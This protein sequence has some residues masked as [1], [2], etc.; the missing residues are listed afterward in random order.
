MRKFLFLIILLSGLT[1]AARGQTMPEID[2]S[3]LPE[4]TTASSLRYWFDDGN[5]SVTSATI[6]AG[7]STADA[8]GLVD[9]IHVLHYQIIDSKGIVGI[10]FSKLFI[11]ISGAL[12]AKSLRYWF[13]DSDANS[14]TSVTGVNGN[15]TIETASLVDGIHIVHYQVVDNKGLAGIPFSK[16]FIKISGA[17]TAKSLRYWFDNNPN[18]VKTTTSIPSGA[19]PIDASGLVEGIHTI[20]YQIVDNNGT[21]GIPVSKM[22]MK[23]GAKTITATAIQYW[24][25]ENDANIKESA[26]DLDNLTTTVDASSLTLGQHVLNYQLKLSDGT[27]SPVATATFETT[28]TL[29]GDAN[30]DGKVNVADIVVIQI[31]MGD[32]TKPIHGANADVTGEGVVDKDDVEAVK[33]IIMTPKE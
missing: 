13:D 33:D 23:L 10:P 7:A 28:Q 20:H 3:G 4:A 16:M 8:S 1:L 24:F 6:T 21:V 30:N 29:K 15:Y 17:L 32:N 9:G 27:L 5:G 22:F 25:D 18:T 12:S 2:L 11:R 14:V 26:I 31:F 19:T